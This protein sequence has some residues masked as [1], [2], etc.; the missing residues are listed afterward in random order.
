MGVAALFWTGGGA[1][2]V[3]VGSKLA[4]LAAGLVLSKTGRVTVPMVVPTVPLKLAWAMPA[5]IGTR[6][7]A[8]K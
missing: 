3:A 2:A 6:S 7:S 1:V 8:R 5:Q 4:M